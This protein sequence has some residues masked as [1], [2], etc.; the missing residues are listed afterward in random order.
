MERQGRP[1]KQPTESKRSLDVSGRL[2]KPEE[3]SLVDALDEG[4]LEQLK[5][6]L[7]NAMAHELRTPLA[8][9]RL[10]VG[11]LVSAPPSGAT[12][13]HHQLFQL[14]LHS[15]DRLDLL[16]NSLLDYVRL[17]SRHLALDIQTV[18]LRLI[19]ESVADLLKPHYRARR[20][21][22]DLQLPEEPINVRGDPFRL[23]NAVQALLDNACK[24]CPEDG[25]LSLGCRIQDENALGWICDTGPAVTEEVRERMF[26]R[27]SWQLAEDS[28]SLE[29]FGLGLPLAHGLITLHGGSLWVA[30]PKPQEIGMCFHFTLPLARP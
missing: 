11:L 16:I 1:A 8:S 27:A 24:R 3:L 29:G 20:Q 6:R 26:S 15:S 7:F 28:P 2:A 19:L 21:K 9:L 12:E 13:E 18:D 23:R 5:T 14:I 17:E 22:L 10:A 4:E 30:Q 25:R